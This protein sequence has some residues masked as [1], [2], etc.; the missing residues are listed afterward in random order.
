VPGGFIL[1]KNLCYFIALG[2]IWLP[3]F[4]LFTIHF[5]LLRPVNVELQTSFI[6]SMSM[7]VYCAQ[8]MPACN[9]F[10]NNLSWFTT[11]EVDA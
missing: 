2:A 3:I 10:I 4:D 11:R 5:T 8:W 7:F 6:D 9:F 1:I